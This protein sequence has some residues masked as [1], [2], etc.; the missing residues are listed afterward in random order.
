MLWSKLENFAR[1]KTTSAICGVIFLFAFLLVGC[2]T[3]QPTS[4]RSRA[5]DFATD[6]FS[7]SNELSW[8]YFFD[9]NGKWVNQRRDPPP[10]YS[11][12]CFVISHA[13]KQFFKH[14]RFDPSKPV[15]DE[16]TYQ[17]LIHEIV[18]G[19]D[20]RPGSEKIDVPGYANLNEFSRAQEKV[21]KAECGGAWRSYFQR[22]HWRIM[23]PFTRGHQARTS[24]N[25]MRALDENGAIVVHV[26]RFPQLTINHALMLAG[27]R[28]KENAVEFL[29]YDPN[30]PHE[31]GAL[32]YDVAS[33]TFF[34]PSN[35]YFYGGKVNVY[36]IYR[37]CLY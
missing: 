21:L 18:F 5:F 25:L 13:A 11:Q 32:T 16:K 35:A 6:T 2:A 23:L 26:V 19:G 24:E 27:Y 7:Y 10:Q 12:H 36:E 14:A 34:L 37:A 1:Q 20:M 15:A 17:R 8:E 33:R 4:R 30:A 3:S 29:V 28:Q 9:A 22:G 31:V